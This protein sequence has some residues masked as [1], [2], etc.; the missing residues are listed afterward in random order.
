MRAHVAK[1]GIG[2]VEPAV[3]VAA[4]SR[5]MLLVLYESMVNGENI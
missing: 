5:E 1:V 4:M 3:V 2:V